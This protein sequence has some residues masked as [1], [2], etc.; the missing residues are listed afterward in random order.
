MRRI[1][2]REQEWVRAQKVRP[3]GGSSLAKTQAKNSDSAWLLACIWL[4]L[5]AG[6]ITTMA[7][8]G[9]VRFTPPQEDQWLRKSF[10][11]AKRENKIDREGMKNVG[12]TRKRRVGKSWQ[13]L[14]LSEH[15]FFILSSRL[16]THTHTRLNDTFACQEP[17][18][19]KRKA[20]RISHCNYWC[21]I[22]SVIGPWRQKEEKGWE[23]CVLFGGERVVFHK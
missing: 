20:K 1:L 11:L 17:S 18:Q 12:K 3:I 2:V 21:P 22:Q 23:V 6:Q 16:H 14:T 15:G 5:G 7:W 13:E 10:L 8:F 19:A 4:A 9:L